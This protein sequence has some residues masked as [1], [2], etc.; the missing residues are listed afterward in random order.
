MPVCMYVSRTSDFIFISVLVA[1]SID[2][3]FFRGFWRS[4]RDFFFGRQL[5]AVIFRRVFP[6]RL[7]WF[8]TAITVQVSVAKKNACI[9]PPYSCWCMFTT[10][11]LYV[12]VHVCFL[13][14]WTYMYLCM[15]AFWI[16]WEGLVFLKKDWLWPSQQTWQFFIGLRPYESASRV[17]CVF[18]WEH[19]SKQ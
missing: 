6:L 4:F 18:P 8:V 13:K 2:C 14:V 15:F 19:V 9:K 7:H 1:V 11:N 5:P 3:G 10:L 17:K 12:R 16:L